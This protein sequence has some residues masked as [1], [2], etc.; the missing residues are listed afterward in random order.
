MEYIEGLNLDEL[1]QR[2][3]PQPAARVMYLLR[4][5]CGSLAEAHT[6]GVIHRDIKPANIMVCERGGMADVV[7]VLDFGLVKQVLR[8]L[9]P[10]LSTADALLGTPKYVSPESLTDPKR[11]GAPTD[12]YALAAV[13]YL[14]LVGEPVFDGKSVMEVCGK[15]MNDP[16]VPPNEARPGSTPAS[17]ERILLR[18]LEKDPDARPQTAG[19]LLD[20]LDACDDIPTWTQA[21]ARRWWETE[22]RGIAREV[23]EKEEIIDDGDAV[24]VDM[25]KRRRR[26]KTA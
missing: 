1:V 6:K 23:S 19:E 26:D 9:D 5:V 15:H 12:L 20:L 21:E 18:C 7:K 4:Q 11:V 10:E 24:A 25:G 22:G 8:D 13:T 17:L 16:P 2:C 3:G 14:L